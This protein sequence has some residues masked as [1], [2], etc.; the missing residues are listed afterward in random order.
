MIS[1]IV[2]RFAW[3]QSFLSSQFH[4]LVNWR[5]QLKLQ[6]DWDS[7]ILVDHTYLFLSEPLRQGVFSAESCSHLLMPSCWD[8]LLIERSLGNSWWLWLHLVP[9]G[10]MALNQRVFCQEIHYQMRHQVWIHLLGSNYLECDWWILLRLSSY[11]FS[12]CLWILY[13][14]SYAFEGVLYCR[15][16]RCTYYKSLYMIKP[17]DLKVCWCLVYGR[18]QVS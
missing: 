18:W 13:S 12:S 10:L 9:L 16:F 1:H 11:S 8:Q 2:W 6:L 15:K 7:S 5:V 3:H 14:Y 17:L 4:V